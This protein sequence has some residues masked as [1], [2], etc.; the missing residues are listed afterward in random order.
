MKKLLVIAIVAVGVSTLLIGC[1]NIKN[2]DISKKGVEIL[3]EIDLD[4]IGEDKILVGG[5]NRCST[6]P[7]DYYEDSYAIVYGKVK[8]VKSYVSDWP[9]LKDDNTD[10]GDWLGIESDIEIEV[11]EDYKDSIEKGDSITFKSSAG[12]V[13]YDELIPEL[14]EKT[15]LRKEYEK[16]E[17]ESKIFM[18]LS[19]D[20]SPQYKVGDYVLVNLM[21]G[22]E[23]GDTSEVQKY[24]YDSFIK[25][26][27]DPNTEEVFKYHDENLDDAEHKLVKES[28]TTLNDL[29][30]K[31][32]K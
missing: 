30:N 28:I 17:N 16:S 8:N 31:Y 1:G 14:G 9:G 26:Y 32:K 10:G 15:F 2:S 29:K 21:Y 7:I 27:V 20:G 19:R 18:Q 5:L 13:S 25:Q 22:I 23:Y 11:I 6:S 12:E 24:I 3:D 4:K